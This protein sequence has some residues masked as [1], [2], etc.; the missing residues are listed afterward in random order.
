MARTVYSK[1]ASGSTQAVATFAADTN[2]R[3]H[4]G[5]VRV[6]TDTSTGVLLLA[7][8]ATTIG[9]FTLATGATVFSGSADAPVF[10]GLDEAAVTLT[11]KGASACAILATAAL[12]NEG[13]N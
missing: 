1:G 10:V 8:G 7:Q 11:V 5:Y 3:W 9:T 4:V 6:E 13:Q 12:E 2:G